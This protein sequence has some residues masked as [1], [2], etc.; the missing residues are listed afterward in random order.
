MAN[1]EFTKG[2]NL[3]IRLEYPPAAGTGPKRRQF[4][5]IRV[6]WK[7]GRFWGYA[8]EGVVGKQSSWEGVFYEG[9]DPIPALFERMTVLLEQGFTSERLGWS[10]MS[11]TVSWPMPTLERPIQSN[12]T[13]RVGLKFL[14]PE[15]GQETKGY[16]VHL[17][18][19]RDIEFL[20]YGVDWGIGLVSFD[21]EGNEPSEFVKDMLR[22]GFVLASTSHSISIRDPA[23]P[24]TKFPRLD[25][26]IV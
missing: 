9:P 12:E 19:K 21:G 6:Y 7:D 2:L 15:A 13:Y 22:S 8:D 4:H 24:I 11:E 3:F 1:L 5:E 25:E 18:F 26:W 14:R 17:N 20:E 16:R 23:W 10:W